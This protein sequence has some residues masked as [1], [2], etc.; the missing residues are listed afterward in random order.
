MQAKK[1]AEKKFLIIY[2]ALNYVKT[3]YLTITFIFFYGFNIV[4]LKKNSKNYYLNIFL[5]KQFL[6]NI[7]YALS[8]IHLTSFT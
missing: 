3:T 4:I 5:V 7:L 2:F 8:N 1:I 6:K